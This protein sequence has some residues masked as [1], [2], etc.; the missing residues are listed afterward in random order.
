MLD[1]CE[2]LLE[3]CARLAEQHIDL[4]LE[5]TRL[6]LESLRA[7]NRAAQKLYHERMGRVEVRV[8]TAEPLPEELYKR[9][10][11]KLRQASATA[12]KKR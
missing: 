4:R 10:A 9:I 7:I 2:H 3:A 1:N 5:A 8:R 11:D 6:R 12:S